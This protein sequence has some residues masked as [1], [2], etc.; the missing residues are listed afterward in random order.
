MTTVDFEQF[1]Q[2]LWRAESR[3]VPLGAHVM[4]SDLVRRSSSLLDAARARTGRADRLRRLL[5]LHP[6]DRRRLSWTNV[7]LPVVYNGAPSS[8]PGRW[9]QGLKYKGSVGLEVDKQQITIAARPTDLV[10]GAPFL[11]RCAT[12]LSTA[13]RCSATGCS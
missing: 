1:M 5:H 6:D 3:Q 12:A 9:S 13:P 2:N 8:R 11:E 10:N 4:K 7:D